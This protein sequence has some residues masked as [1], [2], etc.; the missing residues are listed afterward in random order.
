[1]SVTRTIN[2]NFLGLAFSEFILNHSKTPLRSHL[3]SENT[4]SRFLLQ[5]YSVLSSVKL[6]T[7]V[8]VMEKNKSLINKLKSRNT[9][10][11]PCG[12]PVLISYHELNAEPILV[13]CLRL[14][15]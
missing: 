12:T 14:V 10:I 1:M 8:F 5:L 9:R 15:R 7:F 6:Q 13:F 3:K 11:E 4:F 2:W